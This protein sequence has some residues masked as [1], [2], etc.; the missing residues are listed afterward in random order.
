MPELPEVETMLRGIVAATGSQIV[1]F[2][3]LRSSLRPLHITPAVRV[4]R[5]RVV[6]TTIV[7][8]SRVGK[9]LVLELDTQDRIVIE[10]RM[11][12][13]VLPAD[14]PNRKHLRTI[15]QLKGGP[16]EEVL[17]WDQRGLGV[18]QL[19]SPEEFQRQCGLS[20]LGPDALVVTLDELRARVGRSRRPIKVAMMDQHA[21][22]GIGNLYASEILH[23][24]GV[25][26]LRPC[27]LLRRSRWQRVHTAIREVL[28]EAIRCEG[29]TLADGTYRMG[30]DRKGGYQQYHR[31]YQRAGQPCVQ[32]GRGHIRRIVQAQRSTFYCPGCQR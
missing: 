5:Q 15:L 21:V 32:C 24:A 10:P 11:T 1:E 8:A 27:H 6:G 19:L 22:V 30:R 3:E 18:V 31:V 9:R 16:L 23:R 7:T 13:L 17:F 25:S 14:P 20:R 2:R 4:F 12:G 29:S 28:E 26:P